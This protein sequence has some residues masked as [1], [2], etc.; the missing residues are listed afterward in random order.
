MRFNIKNV[1]LLFAL[2]ACLCIFVSISSIS[3]ADV[4]EFDACEVQDSL[5]GVDLGEMDII[6]S[7]TAD[8]DMVS[9]RQ[10]G[11]G[12]DD[13]FWMYRPLNIF[14]FSK[15]PGNCFNSCQMGSFGN[16]LNNNRA[17]Y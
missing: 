16:Y 17:L 14:K 6:S 11:F 5:A 13:G 12:M 2:F 3:A 7:E 1:K 8:L 9:Y 4:D 15:N 10:T